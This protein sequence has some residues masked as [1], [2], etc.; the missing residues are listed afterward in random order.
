MGY[1]VCDTLVWCLP[2][3][4]VAMLFHHVVTVAVNIALGVPRGARIG[5]A[6]DAE[7]AVRASAF[8]YHIEASVLLPGARSA[9]GAA[10]VG[11]YSLCRGE[12]CLAWGW[13]CPAA[14]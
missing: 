9:T 10:L 11:R 6:G 13:M 2:K 14:H 1:F 3:G 5:G 8:A 12:A 4:D 7:W